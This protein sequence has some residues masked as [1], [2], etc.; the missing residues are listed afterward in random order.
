MAV[1]VEVLQTKLAEAQRNQLLR[2]AAAKKFEQWLQRLKKNGCTA[3][4]YR[5]TG[6]VAERLCVSHFDR[7]WRV[8]VAFE[9]PRR[10]VILLIGVHDDDRPRINIYHQL[11]ELAGVGVPTGKRTKPSCCTADQ[12]PPLWGSEIYGLVERARKLTKSR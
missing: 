3:L 11:Y 2:K 10:A 7:A 1:T 9:T 5:L 4:E 12:P 6:E 8:V